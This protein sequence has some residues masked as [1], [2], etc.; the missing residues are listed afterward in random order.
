M[1]FSFQSWKND[2]MKKTRILKL[3][4]HRKFADALNEFCPFY[5]ASMRDG[6][7]SMGKKEIQCRGQSLSSL[8][9]GFSRNL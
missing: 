7:V 3:Y 5:P 4:L 9:G 1:T 2:M 8:E 6:T